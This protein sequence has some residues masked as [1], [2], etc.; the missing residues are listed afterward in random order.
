MAIVSV[1]GMFLF[2][3]SVLY[4]IYVLYALKHYTTEEQLIRMTKRL[5]VCNFLNYVGAYLTLIGFLLFCM[6]Q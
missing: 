2:G 5:K 4:N 1:V 6:Y 3:V